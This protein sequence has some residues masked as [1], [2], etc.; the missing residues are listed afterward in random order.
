MEQDFNHFAVIENRIS[1]EENYL[2]EKKNTLLELLPEFYLS[3]FLLTLTA[4]PTLLVTF[5]A[6]LFKFRILYLLL[7]FGFYFGL[8]TILNES[9]FEWFSDAVIRLR[10]M[11][12]R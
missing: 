9:H 4:V 6:Y 3:R 11:W 2:F 12:T 7:F 8:L 5:I 1:N 10:Q